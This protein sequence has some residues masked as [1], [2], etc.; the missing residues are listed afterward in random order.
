MF[1]YHLFGYY[2][3][4]A[5]IILIFIIY[6]RMHKMYLITKTYNLEWNASCS[7]PRIANLVNRILVTNLNGA[8]FVSRSYWVNLSL[9]TWKCKSLVTIRRRVA[10]MSN[11]CARVRIKS[12]PSFGELPWYSILKDLYEHVR[13]FHNTK[14]TNTYDTLFT[15]KELGT[16]FRTWMHFT[17]LST[18]NFQHFNINV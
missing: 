6:S 14:L 7:C 15:I 4:L 5:V 3:Q 13:V 9:Y 10:I 1:C 11:S 12:R 17:N 8:G 16:L 18:K 2:A